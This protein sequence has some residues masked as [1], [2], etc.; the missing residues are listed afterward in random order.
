M[1]KPRRYADSLLDVAEAKCRLQPV[2][3]SPGIRDEQVTKERLRRIM[4]SKHA[5]PRALLRAG[6][7]VL[8][9]M[10]FLP[11]RPVNT[12]A[13]SDEV[14]HTGIAVEDGDSRR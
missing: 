14:N 7:L 1:Y 2:V 10:I 6:L 3:T 12:D 4:V 5:K 9:L 11:G 8:A 13:P